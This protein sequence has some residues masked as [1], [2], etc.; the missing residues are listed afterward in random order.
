MADATPVPQ[1]DERPS[2]ARLSSNDAKELVCQLFGAY[3]RQVPAPSRAGPLASPSMTVKDGRVHNP[4]TKEHVEVSAAPRVA[5]RIGAR[6]LTLLC[7]PARVV[8]VR[9]TSS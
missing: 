6:S 3:I 5:R 9:R 4:R 8:F 7:S 1:T 2:T